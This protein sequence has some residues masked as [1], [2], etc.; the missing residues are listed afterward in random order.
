MSPHFHLLERG[1]EIIINGQ[2]KGFYSGQHM[3]ADAVKQ[4]QREM[5]AAASEMVDALIKERGLL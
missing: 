2:N 4:H 3:M 1:H 5:P